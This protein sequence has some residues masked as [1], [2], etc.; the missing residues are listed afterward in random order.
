MSTCAC[1]ARC[2][3]VSS[4]FCG[5][6]SGRRVLRFGDLVDDVLREDPAADLRVAGEDRGADAFGFVARVGVAGDELRLTAYVFFVGAEA[7]DFPQAACC[8]CGRSVRGIGRRDGEGGR[9]FFLT[10]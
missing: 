7:R 1:F 9:S 3:T 2:R 8:G 6:D 10:F 5:V 4:R